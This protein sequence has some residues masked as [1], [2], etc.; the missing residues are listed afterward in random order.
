[1]SKKSK[2]GKT[3]SLNTNGNKSKIVQTAPDTLPVAGSEISVQ[4]KGR[5]MLRAIRITPEL[6]EAAKAYK[7]V[8]GVSFYRLGLEAITDRL[9]K[10]GYINRP[11]E[12]K[13]KSQEAEIA[14]A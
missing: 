8:T 2:A 12:P 7:K 4:P 10:E 9:V 6:L 13:T 5:P 14:K 3:K 11:T 1:M